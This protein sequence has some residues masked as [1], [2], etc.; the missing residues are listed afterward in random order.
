MKIPSSFLLLLSVSL[1]ATTS[2][3]QNI[4]TS[5]IEWNCISTFTSQP[6]TVVDENTKVVSSAEQIIWYDDNGAALKTLSITGSTGSWSNVSNNGSIIFNITSGDDTGIAQFSKSDGVTR[7]RI[8]I[9]IDEDSPVFE[10]KVGT[11]NVQ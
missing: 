9:V 7:I 11:L 10:L 8:H 4:Q 5:T 1:I 6:G 2:F 3:A